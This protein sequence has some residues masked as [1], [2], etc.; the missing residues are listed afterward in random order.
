MNDDVSFVPETPARDIVL[1]SGPE[2]VFSLLRQLNHMV[3]V[4]A[5]GSGKTRAL[6]NSAAQLAA[7]A[8]AT[9]DTSCD[10]P[11]C[12]PAFALISTP[13]VVMSLVRFAGGAS[14]AQ[15]RKSLASGKYCIMIDG[16]N[17]V[18]AALYPIALQAIR[19]LALLFP[20]C[21]LLVTSRIDVYR[22]ELSMATYE[23]Q[24]PSIAEIRSL[25]RTQAPTPSEGDGAFQRIVGD[26][27]LLALFRTPLMTRLLSELPA[28]ASTP[29]SMGGLMGALLGKIYAREEETGDRTPRQVLD[30]VLKGIAASLGLAPGRVLAEKTLLEIASN[31]TNRF[32][33]HVS[34][35]HVLS[36]F[37]QN[38]LIV[39]GSD[40]IGFFHEL[41]LD[42]IQACRLKDAWIAGD[43][44]KCFHA[45]PSQIEL[46]ATLLESPSELISQLQQRGDVLLAAKCYGSS[47]LRPEVLRAQL[48]SDIDEILAGSGAGKHRQFRRH[49]EALRALAYMDERVATARFFQV[50][51]S[52]P[53][54][55]LEVPKR[56]LRAQAPAGVQ[57]I[58]QDVL[59]SGSSSQQLV[60]LDFVG[61]TQFAG[62]LPRVFVLANSTERAVA[63]A[64]A[65]C[66]GRF[67]TPEVRDF[68]LQQA[69]ISPAERS[70]PLH[71]A[72]VEGTQWLVEGL[73]GDKDVR[74]RRAAIAG[75][76]D[77]QLS[78][79]SISSVL[80]LARTNPDFTVRIVASSIAL[81]WPGFQ[82]R[83]DVIASPFELIPV[84]DVEFPAEHI[85]RF[86]SELHN[87]ELALSAL[88]AL[89]NVHGGLQAIVLRKALARSP[90]MLH[91]LLLLTDL[92]SDAIGSGAKGVLL[93]V[94]IYHGVAT[95]A[96]VRTAL[97]PAMSPH[98]RRITASAL[99]RAQSPL[100]SV[101]L[102]AIVGDPEPAIR[103][104]AIA[105]FE[106]V[107]TDLV[108]EAVRMLMN[109]SVWD[110]RR[111]ATLFAMKCG[112]Y[113]DLALA[114]W[115]TREYPSQQ[116]LLV[117]QALYSQ[118]VKFPLHS[119]IDLACDEDPRLRWYGLRILRAISRDGPNRLGR[120][121]KW[122]PR[123]RRGQLYRFDTQESIAFD[124]T[125]IIG[126]NDF[127]QWG[128]C[129]H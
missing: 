6:R 102:M 4:G 128:Y 91:D 81:S 119:A 28:H 18:A 101:A 22:N 86:L 50:I 11:L 93:E 61:R 51:A 105:F 27:R 8:L 107:S 37:I 42:Y 109:D 92:E 63:H 67:D 79:Q 85:I 114:K 38:G 117:V 83:Q 106:I 89:C 48:L 126:Q 100:C 84:A 87:D 15:V 77:L 14:E 129:E 10:I 31:T 36:L 49:S 127:P 110:V 19:S 103:G 54:E 82:E 72:V 26:G 121:R 118:R 21:R 58:V 75:L 52:L 12:L 120:I 95:E 60:A 13:D 113:N 125:N 57:E 90:E 59:A 53:Y 70:F 40:G 3:L 30:L 71:L 24:S 124:A 39:R 88:H 35:T 112:R 65:R 97:A 74:V 96:L 76:K 78:S 111:K 94:A 46:L 56:A 47:S 80:F 55:R 62:A 45:P 9:R 32:A 29:R 17:E 99:I 73:L 64:A 7:R 33:P 108:A 41:A 69:R 104:M 116:R 5:G 16:L 44:D 23:L 1:P 66:I 123:T 34:S 115:S 25:L 43:R 2:P 122:N 68:L 20:R 98:V